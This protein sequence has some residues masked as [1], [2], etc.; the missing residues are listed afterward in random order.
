MLWADTVVKCL[1]AVSHKISYRKKSCIY[2]KYMR[3]TL[4]SRF[5]LRVQFLI[6]EDCNLLFSY[7]AALEESS[8]LD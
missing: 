4:K 7:S 8:W 2:P 5:V 6:D 3:S 1:L